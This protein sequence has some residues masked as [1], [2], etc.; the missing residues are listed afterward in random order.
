M[1]YKINNNQFKKIVNLIVE[2]QDNNETLR[3]LISFFDDIVSKNKPIDEL[4]D[5]FDIKIMNIMLR[6]LSRNKQIPITDKIDENIKKYINE[7]QKNN[8]LKVTGFYSLDTISD[9]VKKAIQKPEI[10]KSTT[11]KSTGGVDFMEITKKVI[12]KMEG[13]Y[14]H[15]STPKN[16]ETSKLG[17]C[18]N[19]PK[20]SMG[21]STETMFGL[22]RYNGNIEKTPEGQEFFN[23]ID[24]EKKQL[25]M[26]KFCEKWKW[27][28]RGG[29]KETQLKE[30]AAT[31]MKN[32]FDRNMN[33][34]VKNTETK[35]RILNNPSLLFHMSYAT[36]NGSGFFKKFA[37]SL[38]NAI[39]QGKSDQELIDIAIQ[40]REGTRLLNKQ[41]TK[42]AILNPLA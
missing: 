20:G 27:L 25:G 22:D 39:K 37:N 5:S 9:F 38:D 33:N 11:T 8:N 28:Y 34:F 1:K 26:P 31:I 15:G 30:L 17:I 2:Q 16:V 12:D 23:I 35:K 24:N 19:H 40:D 42:A 36:W 29:D 4:S 7:Y 18:S 21:K 41:K 13:G 32:S 6:L 3:K 10:K 14:W